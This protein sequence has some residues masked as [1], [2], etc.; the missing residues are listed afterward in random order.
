VESHHGEAPRHAFVKEFLKPPAVRDALTRYKPDFIFNHT[1]EPYN[2]LG[3]F[4]RCRTFESCID[5][6]SQ[7]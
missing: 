3:S 6:F 4:L 5:A 1:R 7:R 2:E